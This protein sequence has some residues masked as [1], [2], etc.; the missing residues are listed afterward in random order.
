MLINRMYFDLLYGLNLFTSYLFIE[1]LGS[2]VE[3][4]GGW[5][6]GKEGEDFAMGR[7]DDS[8]GKGCWGRG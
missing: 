8:G 2:T 3:V 1:L 5:G 4:E 6:R 7:E